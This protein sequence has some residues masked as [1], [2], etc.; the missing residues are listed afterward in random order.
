M[1]KA[2]IPALALILI[3]MMAGC[4]MTNGI[5]TGFSSHSNDTS[6]SGSYLSFDGSVSRRLS[7]KAGDTVTFGWEG[8]GLQPVVERDG[9][10]CYVIVDGGS[11]AIPEDGRYAFSVKGKDENGAF[12]LT[13]RIEAATD[14]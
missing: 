13:W 14:S 9:E 6:L 8:G 2:I 3:A 12:T 5:F 7:L 1:K 11:F 4:T 10:A